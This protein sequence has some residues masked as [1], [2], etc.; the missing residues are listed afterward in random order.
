M[1]RTVTVIIESEVKLP[2]GKSW[3][4]VVQWKV[5]GF[6]FKAL[7][8]DSPEWVW[9]PLSGHNPALPANIAIQTK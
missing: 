1:D 2:D 6:T 5:D 3:D 7:F 4:D 9:I 8:K